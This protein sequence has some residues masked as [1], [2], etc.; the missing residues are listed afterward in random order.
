MPPVAALLASGLWL[1]M[2]LLIPRVPLRWRVAAVWGMVLTG[3]PMLGWLTLHW[4][5]G[6]GIAGFVL[7]LLALYLP[8]RRWRD[9]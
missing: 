9:V 6:P 3:V 8:Q 4:G 7:G 2:A 1:L 5:P